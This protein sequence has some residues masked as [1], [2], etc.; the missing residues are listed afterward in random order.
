VRA[1][2]PDGIDAA[3]LTASG[4]GLDA[5]LNAL[6]RG[7]R[8]A[9]PN[10]VEPVPAARPDVSMQAYDGRATPELLERLNHWI[11]AGPFTVCVSNM[12]PLDRAAEAHRAV[13]RH[14]VGK[15]ALKVASA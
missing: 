2:A 9:Y 8:V 5:V 12:Y 4:N 11:E 3:L 14:H 10:G 6:R 1:F 13:E 7:G 15:V